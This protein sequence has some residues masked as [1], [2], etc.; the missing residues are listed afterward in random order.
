MF[1]TSPVFNVIINAVTI[2]WQQGYMS[3]MKIKNGVIKDVIERVF[4][5]QAI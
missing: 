2:D 3:V 4:A 5:L 1:N